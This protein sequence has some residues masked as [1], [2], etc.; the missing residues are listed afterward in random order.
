[1]S[2]LV[3]LYI[4]NRATE[5][6]WCV[7]V[8][9]AVYLPGGWRVGN[10]RSYWFPQ[11]YSD[12]SRAQP[13]SNLRQVLLVFM[14]SRCWTARGPRRSDDSH[15]VSWHRLAICS[16][17]IAVW[18]QHRM[19]DQRN[20][21][22]SSRLSTDYWDRWPFSGILS[23]CVYLIKP[24]RPTQP[25]H[26]SVGR[27]DEYWRWL[28]PPVLD[29]KSYLEKS[30][31]RKE[32]KNLLALFAEM[33]FSCNHWQRKEQWDRQKMWVNEPLKKVVR[34]SN[35][36][37]FVSTTSYINLHDLLTLFS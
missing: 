19:T 20:Y 26:P 3:G 37:C 30:T 2:A 25:S 21:S 13:A 15:R 10:T 7:T 8:S 16:P 34:E 28:R 9:Y 17:L 33:S 24:P 31:A 27:C 35:Y 4:A 36:F 5:R 11:R 22:T 32:A 6:R 14:C 29:Q 23:I 1:M 12:A 18:L